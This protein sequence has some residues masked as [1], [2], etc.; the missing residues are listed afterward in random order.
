MN[1][2]AV[3]YIYLTGNLNDNVVQEPVIFNKQQ[4]RPKCINCAGWGAPLASGGFS[5]SSGST[6]LILILIKLAAYV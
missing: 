5:L 2:S 6:D 1:V 3:C 4:L